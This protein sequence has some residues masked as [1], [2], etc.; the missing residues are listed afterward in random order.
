MRFTKNIR[1]KQNYCEFELKKCRYQDI[2]GFEKYKEIEEYADCDLTLAIDKLGQL[3]DIEEE[4]GVDL[5]SLFSANKNCYCVIGCEIYEGYV[6]KIYL[7][8][9][10]VEINHEGNYVTTETDYF[11]MKDYGKTW[12]LNRRELL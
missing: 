6:S 12:A 3:E 10:K 8:K 2:Y 4:Y 5:F 11:D 9:R 7:D 1:N